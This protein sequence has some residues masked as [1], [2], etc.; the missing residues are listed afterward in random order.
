MDRIQRA[1]VG[2]ARRDR[3]QLVSLGV[4]VEEIAG[5]GGLHVPVVRIGRRE[6]WPI[7][8]FDTGSG[9]T[10][11]DVEA[12]AAAALL[13]AEGLGHRAVLH[14]REEACEV[15]LTALAPT[16]DA[17]RA[18]LVRFVELRRPHNAELGLGAVTTWPAGKSRTAGP[19]FMVTAPGGPDVWASV[20]WWDVDDV[21]ISGRV[22]VPG[23]PRWRA[24]LAH[25]LGRVPRA[26]G[27]LRAD[28]MPDP[29]RML[30]IDLAG[31]GART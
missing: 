21:D 8:F 25:A 30:T 16:P 20:R 1:L 3:N 10:M 4:A 14:L 13:A 27:L 17:A 5:A 18:G 29:E 23:G 2:F 12:E 31:P 15:E 26:S 7:G 19:G 28:G 6:T 24:D 9:L 11:A 22:S